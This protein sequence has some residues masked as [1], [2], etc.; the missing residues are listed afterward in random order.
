MSKQTT[1]SPRIVNRKA[2][3]DYHVHEKLEVGI[4]LRGTEVKSIRQGKVSLGEGFAMVER[5]TGELWLRQVDIGLY[6]HAPAEAQ[7]EP[8]RPR[9]LLARRR[10]IESLE[11]KTSAKGM[12]LIP[13]A[14]YFKRGL[15]K[16]ELGLATGKRKADKRETMKKKEHDKAMRRAMTR[17]R[18]G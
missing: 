3:H 9:K 6:G 14:L 13:L 17:K 2:Y 8:K 12:T 10:Q 4:A 16:M 15:V 5:E 7:H 11:G 1:H 18:I